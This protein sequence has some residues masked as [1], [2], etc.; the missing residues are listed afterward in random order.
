MGTYRLVMDE[1]EAKEENPTALSL[2][3]SQ[4]F[5]GSSVKVE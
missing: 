4:G 5:C 3:C 1:N 2:N